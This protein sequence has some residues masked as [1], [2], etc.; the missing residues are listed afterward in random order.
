MVAMIMMITIYY[1]DK[2][3]KIRNMY[4]IVVLIMIMLTE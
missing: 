2:N 1:N 4:V 3:K